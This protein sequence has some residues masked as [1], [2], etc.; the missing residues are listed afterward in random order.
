MAGAS[1]DYDKSVPLS[2]GWVVGAASAAPGLSWSEMTMVAVSGVSEHAGR[3]FPPC[4]PR[5]CSIPPFLRT[6][7]SR[8]SW[9]RVWRGVL[10]GSP[11]LG[12]AGLERAHSQKSPKQ[13]RAITFES[14]HYTA[15]GI[16]VRVTLDRNHFFKRGSLCMTRHD[17][18]RRPET[19]NFWLEKQNSGQKSPSM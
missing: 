8:H 2:F 7:W 18:I 3:W 6:G 10:C 14:V 13:N 16:Q 9:Q 17:E 19:Q 15:V 4:R 11:S 1:D 5:R 12:S